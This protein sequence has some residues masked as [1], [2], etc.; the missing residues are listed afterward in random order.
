MNFYG[1][2]PPVRPRHH[3]GHAEAAIK[4]AG[5]EPLPGATVVWALLFA[6]GAHFT[7]S[8]GRKSNACGPEV[9]VGQARQGP[10]ACGAGRAR[11]TG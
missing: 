9:D 10:A 3:G 1:N 5:R 6:H 2:T 4:K 7:G 11:A 8:P